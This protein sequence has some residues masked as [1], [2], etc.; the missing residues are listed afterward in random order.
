MNPRF[1]N[2]L[3]FADLL[4]SI[5]PA[6]LSLVPEYRHTAVLVLVSYGAIILSFMTGGLWGRCW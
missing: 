3:G 2:T 1:H 5:I 6:L 4:P